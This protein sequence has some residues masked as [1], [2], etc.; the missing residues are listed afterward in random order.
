MEVE[1]VDWS[2]RKTRNT[3]Y[4]YSTWINILRGVLELIIKYYKKKQPSRVTWQIW[5]R[6]AIIRAQRRDCRAEWKENCRDTS[7]ST[8]D[9]TCRIANGGD[10]MR[11]DRSLCTWLLIAVTD[12]FFRFEMSRNR[13]ISIF[14][15]L[16]VPSTF[17]I[18]ES[19]RLL[20]LRLYLH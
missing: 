3:A 8:A 7:A 18:Y 17:K 6:F 1:L 4:C 16:V 2:R 12:F 10:E 14:K 5:N 15:F 19:L 11:K 13:I 20:Q 9:S